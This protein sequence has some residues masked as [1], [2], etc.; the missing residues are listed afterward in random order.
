MSVAT[1]LS[2]VTGFV[3]V[4]ATAYALGTMALASAYSVANNIPNMI[5]ELVAGG[6]IS[7]LFIP[8]FM[9]IKASRDSEQAW[10]FASHVFN[11]AVVA[12]GAIALVGIVWPEPFVWTQTFRMSPAAAEN[13]RPAAEAF[14]RFFAIQVV[15]YG[16]GAVV[17]GLLNS[18]RKYLWVALGPVFNNVV[19]IVALFVFAAL[20]PTNEDL[21]FIILAAGTTL[22]VLVMYLVQLPALVR[23]GIRYEFGIDFKD[24]G[25]RRMAALA[26]PL[27]VYVATNL[28]A[29]SFR[30]SSALA[31]TE[32]G[33]AMLMYA[34]TFYQLPYGI[35]AVALATAVFTELSDAA[36]RRD[37]VAFKA[38]FTR[39]LRSTGVLIMPMAAMLMT[40]SEPLIGLYQVG[41]FEPSAV[42]PV[43]SALRWWGLALI[44]F[45][46]TMYL[47]RTFYSLKDTRTPAAVNLVLTGVQI[48]LYMVL[49]TGIGAWAGLGLDGIPIADAVFFALSS[50]ALALMLR[51]HIGGYDMRGVV[52]VYLRMAL[53]SLVA[54]GIAWSVARLVEPLVSG[55]LGSLLQVVT[56]GAVGVV[57]AFSLASLLGVREVDA[58]TAL[59]KRVFG[60]MNANRKGRR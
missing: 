32:E 16:A 34:W 31:V 56:A 26:L 4:W 33:S 47:L 20:Y 58:A 8:T 51:R 50:V 5:Y 13:V 19:V 10:R 14:F 29:V 59:V 54:S 6:I 40:L 55:V 18:E 43:A 57:V 28:V 1:A 30:N 44:F 3:R 23:G 46:T 11:L 38:D 49:S 37:W 42:P 12:L 36:G 7:S 39:G 41:R 35:L 25:I 60:R 53:A 17:S 48:G 52:G 24:P 27:L 9:E 22:G 21:A 2:R 45:A 15:F